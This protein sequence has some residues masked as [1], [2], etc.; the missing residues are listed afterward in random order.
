VKSSVAVDGA[1]SASGL[2]EL[3]NAFDQFIVFAQR[4]ELGAAASTR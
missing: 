4:E 3:A 2:A 1:A